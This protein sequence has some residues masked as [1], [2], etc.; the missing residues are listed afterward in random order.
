MLLGFPTRLDLSAIGEQRFFEM[1]PDILDRMEMVGLQSGLRID[2][3]GS[4]SKVEITT[5][6]V[7]TYKVLFPSISTFETPPPMTSKL[8]ASPLTGVAGGRQPPSRPRVG[9]PGP[10]HLAGD[11]RPASGFPSQNENSPPQATSQGDVHRLSDSI[12]EILV[13]K[14]C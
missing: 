12:G 9:T 4:V 2:R 13:V 11:E 3:F 5:S 6:R 7:L 14:K 1:P 8:H 10:S